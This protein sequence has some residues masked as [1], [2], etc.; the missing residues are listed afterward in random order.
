MVRCGGLPGFGVFDAGTDLETADPRLPSLPRHTTVA[1][2]ARGVAVSGTGS[3]H[4]IDERMLHDICM[5]DITR[6]GFRVSRQR[7][8]GRQVR[9]RTEM[10]S[11]HSFTRSSVHRAV[12]RRSAPTGRTIS[13]CRGMMAAAAATPAKAGTAPRFRETM[14]S[15]CG[16]T[17][18]LRS[19]F[20]L[21]SAVTKD[22]P[23]RRDGYTHTVVM[24][25][26][27]GPGRP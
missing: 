1:V 5:S 24:A 8:E 26:R 6:C 27:P 3:C 25:P 10:A 18:E 14:R 21:T 19:W 9:A 15:T 4:E 2:K 16:G 12:A 17:R 22:S 20:G 11:L 23:A 13:A 7:H